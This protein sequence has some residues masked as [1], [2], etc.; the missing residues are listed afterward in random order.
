MFTLELLTVLPCV[1][2]LYSNRMCGWYEVEAAC[3][4]L[5]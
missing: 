2:R 4:F 1:K 3:W 5:E